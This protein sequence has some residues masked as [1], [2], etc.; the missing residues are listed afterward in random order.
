MEDKIMP[1]IMRFA[2]LVLV[3]LST[4]A[5]LSTAQV[6]QGSEINV[7][8]NMK[9]RRVTT[10][11]GNTL[12]GRKMAVNNV[13]PENLKGNGAGSGAVEGN[14]KNLKSKQ[15]VVGKTGKCES[16]KSD[17]CKKNLSLSSHSFSENHDDDDAGFVAFNA[18]YHAPRHHPPK[19]N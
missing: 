9:A 4:T 19:N 12:G 18:D 15:Q 3:L 17:D 6:H 10:I 5:C 2:C 7:V 8:S 16:T 13:K 14:L 11:V 1:V